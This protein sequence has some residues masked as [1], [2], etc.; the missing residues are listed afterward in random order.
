LVQ[1][2]VVPTLDREFGR[3]ENEIV[4]MHFHVVVGT[5]GV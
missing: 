5:G 3:L 2:T 4:D 1:V